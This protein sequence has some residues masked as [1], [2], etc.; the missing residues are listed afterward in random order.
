MNPATVQEL[1]WAGVLVALAA[2]WPMMSNG[3]WL[4]IGV[5]V[6]MYTT[7]A[8]SWMLF[9]GPTHYISLAS[10]AFFGVGGFVVG[11][12]QLLSGTILGV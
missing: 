4:G 12:S 3:Y 8:T 7:L 6:M 9:S 2:F 11:H 1:I 10:A 5:D